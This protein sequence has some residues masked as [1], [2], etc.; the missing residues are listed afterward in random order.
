MISL[1]V[2]ES[3]LENL[4][5]E[6]ISGKWSEK[7]G[8]AGNGIGMFVVKRLIL[9]NKGTVIFISRVDKNKSVLF[10]NVPYDNNV[11]EIKLNK[12]CC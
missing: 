11:I 2:E 7:T 8:L 5:T 3:E 4:F 10:E 1:R 9:L 12:N 6:N